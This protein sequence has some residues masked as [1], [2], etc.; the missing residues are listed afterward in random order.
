MRS[1]SVKNVDAPEDFIVIKFLRL[2][3][4]DK[5]VKMVRHYRIRENDDPAEL[6]NP[7]QKFD[8]SCLLLVI[9]EKSPVR[10]SADQMVA[11]CTL[12]SLARLIQMVYQKL[13]T[14]SIY[15][16]NKL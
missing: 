3:N 16:I 6:L 9:E 8:R 10:Q 12:D 1:V 15:Y 4:I 11:P 7:S 2:G 13:F 5:D 14:T